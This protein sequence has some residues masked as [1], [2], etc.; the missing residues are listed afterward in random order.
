MPLAKG[1][2]DPFKDDDAALPAKPVGPI[3]QTDMIPMARPV[4]D[5]PPPRP[6]FKM[7]EIPMTEDNQVDYAGLAKQMYGRNAQQFDENEV[8]RDDI[9]N[10]ASQ[11]KMRALMTGFSNAAAKA[12]GTESGVGAVAKAFDESDAGLLNARKSLASE[13]YKQGIDSLK[14]MEDAPLRMIKAQQFKDTNDPNSKLSQFSRDFYKK[15][16]NGAELPANMSANDIAAFAPDIV[17]KAEAEAER[18]FKKEMN[19]DN[20]KFDSSEKTKAFYRD[21]KK[22]KDGFENQK[23]M[24]DINFENKRMVEKEK[25]FRIGK[26]KQIEDTQFSIGDKKLAAQYSAGAGSINNNVGVLEQRLNVLKN[27]KTK[28][29]K[30]A[31][32]YTMLKSINSLQNSDAVSAD[33]ARMLA[34]ELVP[35]LVNDLRS[36][37]PKIGIDMDGFIR[38]S[39]ALIKAGY[40]AAHEN[41]RLY[42]DL[43]KQY[44]PEFEAMSYAKTG[45]QYAGKTGASG[46]GQSAERKVWTPPSQTAGR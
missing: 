26:A 18:V 46:D 19:E 15:L 24:A 30:V 29:D 5:A 11:S 40:D 17:K 33:E 32:A 39:E 31:I 37:K 4:M 36:G 25:R 1:Y 27:A 9:E 23:E 38:K 35:Y 41:T 42:N 44:D 45:S 3:G 12:G 34:M 28:E 14:E 13:G 10:N 22:Q 6:A 43:Y 16:M 2:R 7:S 20:Q 8:T 21:L